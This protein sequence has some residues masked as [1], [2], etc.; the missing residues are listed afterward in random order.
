[1]TVIVRASGRA[2]ILA[3][4]PSLVHM[5]PRNSLVFLAFRGKRTC[6]AIRFDLPAAT[7]QVVQKRVVTSMIGTLCKLPGVDAV[8]PVVYTDEAFAGSAI[9]PHAEFA[10]L[11]AR[12]LELSGFEL[13]E[14]LCQASDGWASYFE[15]PVPKGGHP[16][17]LITTSDA[18]QHIP[19][20]LR[21]LPDSNDM[22]RRVADAAPKAM[23][24]MRKRLDTYKR[25]I[26]GV[27]GDSDDDFPSVLWPLGDLPLLAEE[28]LAW[29]AAAID[30]HG[31]LL[32]FALQGPPARDLMMLQWAT[33]IEV[34]EQI[35]NAG[36]ASAEALVA[37][38]EHPGNADVGDLMMGIAPRPDADRVE[39]GI[40]LLVAVVPQL[41]DEKRPPLLCMLAW[42]NWALGLGSRAGRYLDE[43]IAI[44]PD[45]SMAAVL[46]TLFGIGL[47]EWAFEGRAR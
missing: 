7:S 41:A 40:A 11:L 47:P 25:L 45:Y 42:L 26:E 30:E 28:A 15:S 17:D 36:V 9:I 24:R 22:P 4:V 31:A 10:D 20:D 37:S 3:M 19:H 35:W 2:D 29:D 23:V 1:M 12:R 13:R 44:D 43:V 39:K 27:S 6:G 32:A 46:S 14:S 33:S 16:L 5:V 34:G 8:V 21:E 18:V 38:S